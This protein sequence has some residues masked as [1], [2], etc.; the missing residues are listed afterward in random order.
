MPDMRCSAE[1]VQACIVPAPTVYLQL[2]WTELASFERRIVSSVTTQLRICGSCGWSSMGLERVEH[3][4]ATANEA[5]AGTWR[6]VPRSVDLMA[7]T[8]YNP[9]I[10]IFV[11]AGKNKIWLCGCC[12]DP[13]R[14]MH[15]AHH[16]PP[17]PAAWA[18]ALFVSTWETLHRRFSLL[19]TRFSLQEAYYGYS[20]GAFA[21]TGVLPGPLLRH[22][23]A[24][25]PIVGDAE[26]RVLATLEA[27]LGRSPI[28]CAFRPVHERIV[29]PVSAL[30]PSAWE[31]TIRRDQCRDPRQI[32][33]GL[34]EGYATM[35]I[36]A[37]VP[38]H[39]RTVAGNMLC[40]DGE[41]L[42]VHR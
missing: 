10:A 22:R 27:Y 20:T 1:P 2:R 17:L 25:P 15:R 36:H 18:N 40:I 31:H 5:L 7:A 14:R 8:T 12:R 28:H 23:G 16:V 19:D 41:R 35:D 9:N 21:D 4:L 13:K 24:S 3:D 39:G 26:A 29:Q 37:A 38:R 11:D 34:P 33:A 30:A 6:R 42:G 32:E